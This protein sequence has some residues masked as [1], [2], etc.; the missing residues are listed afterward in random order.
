MRWFILSEIYLHKEGEIKL[1]RKNIYLIY[2]DSCDDA[3][4]IIGYIEGTSED[5]DKYCSEYNAKVKYSWEEIT[6]ELLTNLLE[7]EE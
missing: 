1:Y 4:T 7:G 3:A 5:A 2:K 6:W